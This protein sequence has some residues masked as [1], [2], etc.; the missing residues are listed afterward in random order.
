MDELSDAV[1]I[2]RPDHLLTTEL[3]FFLFKT[4]LPNYP[5]SP[6]GDLAWTKVA[7]W[8]GQPTLSAET[9]SPAQLLAMQK[10][11]DDSLSSISVETL[12][13]RLPSKRRRQWVKNSTQQLASTLNGEKAKPAHLLANY[14]Q[15]LQSEVWG[16]LGVFQAVLEQAMSRLATAMGHNGQITEEELKSVAAMLRNLIGSAYGQDGIGNE[17]P[18]LHIIASLHA[19]VRYDQ[20]RKYKP[21]DMEDFHHA[22]AALPY[23]QVF[24]TEKSLGHLLRHPPASLSKCYDC[25]VFSDPGDALD[26]L[27]SLAA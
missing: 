21:N 1:C 9:L 11:M 5:Q 26:H 12:A 16:V 14:R 8:V 23:C 7:Y 27:R 24:L 13:S 15:F 20:N 17:V 10:A 2:Q 18:Q 4:M 25:A 22:G 19:S 6:P 3:E